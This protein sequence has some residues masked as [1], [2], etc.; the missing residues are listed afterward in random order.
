T[1]EYAWMDPPITRNPW[2]LERT[3]GGSS[4]GSAA[5]VACGMCLGAIGSQT[6]GSIT[7]PASY[8]G[9]AGVKPGHG[10]IEV[11]GVLPFAPSLDHPGP[12]ARSVRDLALL[13]EVIGRR[14]VP[15]RASDLDESD[16]PPVLGRLREFFD[17]EAEPAMRHGFDGAIGR[18]AT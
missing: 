12:I 18:L 10:R 15:W 1:T 14:P 13:Y 9:V 3:P 8:C 2:N 4:S 16:E 11:R 17:V 7:R 6:G 5:A